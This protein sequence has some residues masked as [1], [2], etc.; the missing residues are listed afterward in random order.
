[1]YRRIRHAHVKLLTLLTL[2]VYFFGIVFAATHPI[3]YPITVPLAVVTYKI[4]QP[5]VTVKYNKLITLSRISMYNPVP[6]QTDNNPESSSCGPTRPKQIAISQ[7]LFFN[8]TGKKYL[9]GKNVI[10]VTSKG[11]VYTGYVIND[12]LNIRYHTTVDILS[13]SYQSAVNFGVDTGYVVITN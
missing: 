13:Q 3:T 8:D 7:D 10:V 9:C 4:P 1:M 5:T 11:E 6:N 2:S 12:T